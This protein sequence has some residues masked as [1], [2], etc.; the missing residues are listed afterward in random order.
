MTAEELLQRYAA[1]ERDFHNSE[2]RGELIAAALKGINLEKAQFDCSSLEGSDFSDSNLSGVY[3]S[4]HFLYE[5]NF[6]GADLSGS[7]AKLW[8]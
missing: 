5:C 7:N 8:G 2:I 1:G 4:D 3:L 6:S